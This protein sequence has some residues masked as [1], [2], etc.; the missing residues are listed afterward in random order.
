MNGIAEVALADVGRWME[1]AMEASVE[2]LKKKAR[3]LIHTLQSRIKDL[4]NNC[5]KLTSKSEKEML[6][7]NRKTFRFA[8]AASKFGREMQELIW[9]IKPPEEITYKSLSDFYG[10]LSENIRL[11]EQK[12]MLMYPKITPF[13][14][15][16]R[17]RVDSSL[18]RVTDALKDLDSFLTGD[19]SRIKAVDNIMLEAESLSS[20]YKNLEDLEERHEELYQEFSRMNEKVDK[21]KGNLRVLEEDSR[22]EEFREVKMK[23]EELQARVNHAFRHLQKPFKKL[24]NLSRTTAILMLS[25]REK[26][27]EY[28]EAPFT[29][30]ATEE[31]GYPVLKEVLTKLERAVLE[32]KLTLKSRRV[33]KARGVISRIVNKDSLLPLQVECIQALRREQELSASDSIKKLKAEI[34]ATESK[35]RN[36]ESQRDILASRLAVMER[37]KKEIQEQIKEGEERL[38]RAIYKLTNQKVSIIL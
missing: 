17:M 10:L 1:K 23:I 14:I 13:F 34:E 38:E 4:S 26:V 2:P 12:R 3:K 28:L 18:K 20:L 25:E 30:L 8:R 27:R 32:D 22:L 36:L 29:A 19:F 9:D 16:D 33:K 37:E 24:E 11:V 5:E 6:K 35:L 7:E 15:I 31:E 21:E